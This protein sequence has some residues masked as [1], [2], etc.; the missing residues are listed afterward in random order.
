[1]WNQSIGRAGLLRRRREAWAA[2]GRL[3]WTPSLRA[4]PS[5]R[6]PLRP[7]CL[8]LLRAALVQHA[9]RWSVGTAPCSTLHVVQRN[10]FICFM[11]YR[12][13]GTIGWRSSMSKDCTG[14]IRRRGATA[15]VAYTFRDIGQLLSTW[16]PVEGQGASSLPA[17]SITARRSRCITRDPRRQLGRAAGRSLQDQR[18]GLTLRATPF[19]GTRSAWPAR[20]IDGRPATGRHARRSNSGMPTDRRH[21]SAARRDFVGKAGLASRTA[22]SAP[23]SRRWRRRL[24]EPRRSP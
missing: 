20:P 2:Q 18:I 10:D 17:T 21:R 3:P 24:K 15:H 22:G 19:A 1:M 23:P 7:R 5:T 9:R 11:T 13:R 14:P 8:R 12:R 4:V 16:R 6:R